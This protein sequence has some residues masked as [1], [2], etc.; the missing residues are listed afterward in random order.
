MDSGKCFWIL[1]SVLDS[2][3][4][5]GF[6]KVFL[7]SGKCFSILGRVLD[8]GNCFGFW[9][10]FLDSG[11]CFW[12]L[13]RVLDS[14]KCFVLMSH[15]RFCISLLVRYSQTVLDSGF[16]VS[17][18]C[19]PGSHRDSG[20]SLPAMSSPGRSGGGALDVTVPLLN[21]HCSTENLFAGKRN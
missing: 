3:T 4:C 21:R 18:N 13:G 14:G 19:T 2:G 10:V 11:T 17:E 6:W 1:G 20:F 5:F 12:I 9:E 15:R 8:S 16:F 7:D